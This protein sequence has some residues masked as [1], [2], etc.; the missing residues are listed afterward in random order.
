MSW[1]R[2]SCSEFFWRK[3]DLRCTA[4]TTI[5]LKFQVI[6]M[7]KKGV[8]GCY[9]FTTVEMK[10]NKL[11]RLQKKKNPKWLGG[12]SQYSNLVVGD[13]P[14]WTGLGSTNAPF[15]HRFQLYMIERPHTHQKSFHRGEVGWGGGWGW[16]WL[17]QLSF[18]PT[19][20]FLHPTVQLV[21]QIHWKLPWSRNS[22]SGLQSLGIKENNIHGGEG[23]ACIF[24]ECACFVPLLP[25][26]FMSPL[27]GCS[28][29]QKET[30]HRRRST[31]GC[32]STRMTLLHQLH[33]EVILL[34][35]WCYVDMMSHFW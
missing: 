22:T 21:T 3:K 14:D 23:G 8:G 34:V 18:S 29:Q 5:S 20:P 10:A 25:C 28:N 27:L 24:Q 2:W 1:Y 13:K 19:Q 6:S 15:F 35:S 32:P 11:R 9:H 12:C 7:L 30:V 16:G 17:D 26:H 4:H 33:T 31:P